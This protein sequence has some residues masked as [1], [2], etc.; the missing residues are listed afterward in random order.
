[1]IERRGFLGRVTALVLAP[2]GFP[3]KGR[4]RQAPRR[5]LDLSHTDAPQTIGVLARWQP[6]TVV[7][8]CGQRVHLDRW[9]AEDVPCPCGDPRHWI[10]KCEVIH[11]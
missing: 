4:T 5:I 11:D 3:F 9:P 1:M 2:L 6:C 10:V 8:P 7:M